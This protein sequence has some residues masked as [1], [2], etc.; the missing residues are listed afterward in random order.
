MLKSVEASAEEI[1]GAGLYHRIFVPEKREP[2][3]PM[4]VMVHGRTGDANVMW[5]FSR[6]FES[7]HPL[8]IAPQ[9]PVKDVLGGYSW[10]RVSND[11]Q[12]SNIHTKI[13]NPQEVIDAADRLEAF[14]LKM[15]KRYD[16]ERAPVYGVG[17][18][19]GGALLSGLA[20]RSPELLSGVA[21]LASFIPKIVFEHSEGVNDRIRSGEVKPPPFFFAHGSLDEIVPIDRAQ[22]SAQAVR[23]LGG[24]VQFE[25]DEV[26]HKTGANALKALAVWFNERFAA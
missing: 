22:L 9:G 15:K 2:D 19:Q 26:G 13:A 17:F 1:E 4:V 20:L 8:T 24:D 12:P 5:T 10:W 3:A 6:V 14:I 23:D 18:S 11:N 7:H 21:M 25:I 16:A